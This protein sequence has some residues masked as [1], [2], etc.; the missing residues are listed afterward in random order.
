MSLVWPT[1]F[2]LML[3]V[4]AVLLTTL[5]ALHYVRRVRL[6]RPAVG[7][8]NGRDIVVLL[9]FIVALPLLYLVLPRWLLTS[10]LVLTVTGS[11][12]IGYRPVVAPPVRWIAI[13]SLV[14]GN[15]WLARTMLGTV[16]GWQV[17]WAE[18]SVLVILAAVSVAN[19]YVQGGMHLRHVAWL[20]L[21]LAAYDVMFTVVWPVNNALAERFLGF[22]LDPSVGMRIGIYN[23]SI[24]LGDLL[25]YALFTVAACKAYGPVAARIALSVTVAFGAVAPS[26]AP[27]A[28]SV[29]IDGRTDLVV[30]AQTL[31][32]PAAFAA[33]LWL[34]RRYGTERTMAEYLDAAR[35][36]DDATQ[37]SFRSHPARPLVKGTAAV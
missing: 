14:G 11:L 8:F 10:F 6:D 26:L 4:S 17:F 20:A 9:G 25:V 27:L 13:G 1:L 16:T 24:G 22:P 19:L 2:E 12:A 21:I 23:A 33:Y 7:T 36:T 30:P 32:G 37:G 5:G 35:E 29:F 31:F 18:N 3:A 34:R 28:S 15:I